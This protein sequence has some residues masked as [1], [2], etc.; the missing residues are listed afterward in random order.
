MFAGLL[1]A[2]GLSNLLVGYVLGA[3]LITLNLLVLAR[4]IPQLVFLQSGAVFFLLVSFYARLFFTGA[5]L[6]AAIYFVQLN[7][8]GIVVGLSTMLVSFLAWGG[9]FFV[10]RKQKEA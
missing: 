10:S 3:L 4:L 8:L 1:L 9:M 7:A 2:A 5:V 6:F